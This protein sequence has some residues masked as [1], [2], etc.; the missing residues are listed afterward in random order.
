MLCNFDIYWQS[1]S[2]L[3]AFLLRA[4]AGGL[5]KTSGA[6]GYYRPLENWSDKRRYTA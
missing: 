4:T 1:W 5:M 2:P 6:V 3:G